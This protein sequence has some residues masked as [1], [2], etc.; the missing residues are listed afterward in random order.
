MKQLRKYLT[1][2]MYHYVRDMHLTQYPGIKG[3]KTHRFKE[4]LGYFRRFYNFVSLSDCFRFLNGDADVLP[5]NPLLLTFDDGFADHYKNVFPILR[6]F[7]IS[8]LFF[9]PVMSV[10]DAKMLPVHKIHFILAGADINSV[11]SEIKV[12]LDLKRKKYTDI[13]AFEELFSK[14]AVPNHLDP[15]EVIFVKRLLQV[16]LEENIRNEITDQLFE[17]FTGESESEFAEKLYLNVSMIREMYD[18]GM[19]F[20]GHGYTHRW[21]NSINRD[22]QEA[23]VKKSLEFLRETGVITGSDCSFCYPYGGYDDSL[24]EILRESGV[25]AA[26]TTK[27]DFSELSQEN[28]LTLERFDTV[29][30]PFDENVPPNEYTLKALELN[31]V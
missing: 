1:T 16:E 4:Q 27:V 24:L 29:H 28:A 25:A 6:D 17:K 23:E 14:L 30:F 18:S 13:P 12:Q 9:P 2:V 26:F 7:K 21:L 19:E 31:N 11:I 3:V 8:G 10:K 20:G 22:E 15:G 5:D